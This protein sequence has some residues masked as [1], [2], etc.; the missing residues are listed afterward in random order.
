M[1]VKI[2]LRDECYSATHSLDGHPYWEWMDG[3][4][5][6]KPTHTDAEAVALPSRSLQ[7]I[8]AQAEFQALWSM[9]QERCT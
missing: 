1:L 9:E 2:T 3:Y 7:P 4:H 8:T 5:I 6:G